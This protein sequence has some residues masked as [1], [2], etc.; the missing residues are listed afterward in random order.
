MV[1]GKTVEGIKMDKEN[2][3]KYSP[4]I[5][6]IMGFFIS[7]NVFVTPANLEERLNK[8]D[9]HIAATYGT[10]AE[11]LSHQRQLDVI[12]TKIDKIYDYIIGKK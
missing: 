7:Y 1:S 8:F 2:I 9:E 4:I 6:V 12:S 10:K 11:S 3:I 5:I